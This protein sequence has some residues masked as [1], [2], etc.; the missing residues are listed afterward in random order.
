MKIILSRKG[1]DSSIQGGGGA[2]IVFE[3]EIFPIPIPEVGNGIE[4]RD[5]IFHN[6]T[7]YLDVMRDLN[8]N[9]FTECHFDP[10]ITNKILTKDS[11][12]Q[13]WKK[14]L[15]QCDIAQNILKTTGIVKGDL[16]I[17]FGW[18]NKVEKK[19]AKYKYTN[20]ENHTKE[21]VQLIYGY[22]QVGDEII[23]IKKEDKDRID[24]ISSHPHFKQREYFRGEN[25]IYTANAN[26]SLNKNKPGAGI[27]KFNE[28]LILTQNKK[29]R[30]NWVLPDI[31]HPSNGVEIKYLPEQNWSKIKN[32]KTEIKASSRGQEFVVVKDKKKLIEKWAIDLIN[33]N[34][35]ED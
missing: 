25:V 9:Q 13:K 4:Y 2:N 5:L 10:Y 8:I 24:W 28:D 21:G 14:S 19:D 23:N 35:V 1:F 29:S 31:F 26:F 17:F 7:S 34:E 3:N 11:P 16:F 15:G 32:N 12:I 22:L 20:F 27:F 6:G 18:F 33:N 30:T